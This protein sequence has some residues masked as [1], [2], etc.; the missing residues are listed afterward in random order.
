MRI[1]RLV[2]LLIVGG[3]A[4]VG[5]SFAA[6]ASA[7]PSAY[8]PSTGCSVSTSNRSV[9]PGDSLTV[10]GSGFPAGTSVRLT[11]ESGQA[12]GTVHTD[13]Q[14]SFSTRLTIPVGVSQHDRVVA[15][16]SSTTCSFDWT[17]STPPAPAQTSASQTA[18]TG[19]AAI[20]AT[21]IAFA[22]VAGGVLFVVVG[23]RRRA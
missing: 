21:V 8:P 22:L 11:L 5:L 18:Y 19:F 13:S 16:S 23:R 6:N 10:T 2:L 1:N 9:S 12:L 7:D 3:L 20:T 14:G 15:A 4:L 17:T